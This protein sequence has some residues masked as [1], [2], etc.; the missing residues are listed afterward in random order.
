M[1]TVVAAM[2]L[3]I[4]TL[5]LFAYL[6]FSTDALSR[7][8]RNGHGKIFSSIQFSSYESWNCKSFFFQNWLLWLKITGDILSYFDSKMK[9][10]IISFLRKKIK[11]E[12]FR[13]GCLIRWTS[14]YSWIRIWF[15][16]MGFYLTIQLLWYHI[17]TTRW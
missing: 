2:K 10:D 14:W 12:L 17:D 7:T 4:I 5:N 3:L 6:I 1:N 15:G 8:K 13:I 9:A 11:I 16:L